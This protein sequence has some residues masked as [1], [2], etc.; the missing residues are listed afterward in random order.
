MFKYYRGAILV[1]ALALVVGFFLGG[2]AGVAIVA[3]L[4]VLETSL[5]FD[6]S[7]VDASI[8]K[9]WS[10][11]WR[12]RFLTFGM[13]V[14][15][16]G[17]RFAFPLLIVAVVANM[18]PINALLLAIHDPKQY[19]SILTSVH[20]EISAFGGAFLMMLFLKFFFDEEKEIYWVSMI[21]KPLSM[22]ARLEAI[23]IL[24]VLAT[25]LTTAAFIAPGEKLAFITAGVAGLMAYVAAD[26]IGALVGGDSIE[27]GKRIIKEG[28][29]GLM[30]VELIDATFSFDGVIAAFALTNNV[31]VMMVGLAIGAMAVRSMTLHLVDKGA[32]SEFRYLEHGAFWAIGILAIIMFVGTSVHVPEVVTGLVG[33]CA[34]AAALYSSI[35]ANRLDASVEF[36]TH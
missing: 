23:E 34:I 4:G 32:L 26:G 19:E 22:L 6:N 20:N 1:A 29:V 9:N 31:F 16:F 25:V 27:G 21:E 10:P 35:R 5:S 36:E 8:I 15:V 3:V 14:A 28:I 2:W 33:A 18:G 30:Y 7:V 11:V 17:M 13:P 24:I 12:N